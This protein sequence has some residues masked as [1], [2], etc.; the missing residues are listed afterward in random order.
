MFEKYADKIKLLEHFQKENILNENFQLY[1]DSENKI[2]IYYA[3]HNEII[4]KKAKIFIVGIT[5]GWTQTS[6]A[7]KTAKEGL[8]R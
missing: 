6:I 7:Y 5:P 1:S 2:K 8:V 3:P 4:N